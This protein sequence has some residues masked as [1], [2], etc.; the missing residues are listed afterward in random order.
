[1]T[2]A[3][4][5][6][7]FRALH[8]RDTPLVLPNAWD[9]GSARVIELAGA[10]AILTTSAGVAASLGYA[11]GERIPL[12]LVMAAVRRIVDTVAVPV[13][14]DFEE[15]YGATPAAVS[16]TVGAL[17]EAG[18]IGINLEDAMAEPD[19]LVGKIRALRDLAARVRVP[20]FVNAR[21]DVY[22]AGR[23]DAASRFADAV[24]RLRAYEEAGADGLFV[25][26][27]IEPQ[28]ITALLGEVTLPV[29]LLAWP[30][31]PSVAELGRL[32]VKRI[33]VGSG[34]MRAA[35]TFTQRIARDLLTHGTYDGFADAMSHGEC[36]RLFLGEERS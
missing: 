27:L 4:K 16:E 31:C 34:P 9:A 13:S 11:D 1:M 30:G 2:Q 5:A 22:L 19:V 10:P 12:D 7:R 24:R 21:T 20:L 15:G 14:V 23:G 18:A 17:L 26:G 6:E 33:S 25:P 8:H 35:L 32:G 36:N 28:A 3:E 29:N